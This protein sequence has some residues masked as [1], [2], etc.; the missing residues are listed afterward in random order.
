MALN[1][2]PYEEKDMGDAR[3]GTTY[4]PSQWFPLRL[5]IG[6]LQYW[7]IWKE[8]EGAYQDRS[9]QI[10]IQPIDI[11]DPFVFNPIWDG[12][13]KLS[14]MLSA[15]IGVCR[16]TYVESR[17]GG[18]V[19]WKWKDGEKIAKVA[20]K[21]KARADGELV[22][23]R[24][25][26]LDIVGGFRSCLENLRIQYHEAWI[27]G[28]IGGGILPIDGGI[29]HRVHLLEHTENNSF[30]LVSMEFQIHTEQGWITVDGSKNAFEW[31]KT[32]P[33]F[34]KPL[35]LWNWEADHNRCQIKVNLSWNTN[36]LL[37]E[38]TWA[39]TITP[40]A[41][42]E[43]ITVFGPG[44]QARELTNYT[45]GEERD[46]WG[47]YGPTITMFNDG[48]A[49]SYISAE[50]GYHTQESQYYVHFPNK[51]EFRFDYKWVDPADEWPG[52][53]DFPKNGRVISFDTT[54][55]DAMKLI[56]PEYFTPDKYAS[57]V[58]GHCVA[59]IT[60]RYSLSASAQWWDFN[61]TH[62]WVYV[63][64]LPVKISL[65]AKYGIGTE[66]NISGK[67]SSDFSDQ[68]VTVLTNAE[69]VIIEVSASLESLDWSPFPGDGEQFELYGG[70]HLEYNTELVELFIDN[71]GHS[72][73]V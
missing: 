16:G 52:W 26:W 69:P 14:G 51:A 32:I 33:E 5:G 59:K 37:G 61:N 57:Y 73:I 44:F 38:P 7:D 12:R 30:K 43:G 54:I 28:D 18:C 21:L 20:E 19:L 63:D 8:L 40:P 15:F 72:V 55:D 56:I 48:T 9:R 6:G 46:P 53:H 24:A 65:T 1:P 31:V 35:D 13:E 60:R 27:R 47:I 64:G 11:G 4:F 23:H 50:F 42:L 34:Q 25:P 62:D 36:G 66:H 10:D 2:A 3:K 67:I 22:K 71:L 17:A 39:Q 70:I 45:Y 49:V 29:V 68:E 41:K 58:Y